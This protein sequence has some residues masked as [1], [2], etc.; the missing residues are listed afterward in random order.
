[1]DRGRL[2]TVAEAATEF[3]LEPRTIRQWIDRGRIAWAVPG[4]N[5][6]GLVWEADVADAERAT[7]RWPR[8]KRLNQLAKEDA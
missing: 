7:R 4:Q 6:P 2:L 1:M 8:T 3:W 5:S